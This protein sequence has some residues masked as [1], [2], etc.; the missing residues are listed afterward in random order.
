MLPITVK[1]HKRNSQKS[2]EPTRNI[3]KIYKQIRTSYFGRKYM[4]LSHSMSNGGVAINREQRQSP[5][6]DWY[7]GNW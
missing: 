6:A 2:S 5:S 1:I 4:V 3:D 7:I